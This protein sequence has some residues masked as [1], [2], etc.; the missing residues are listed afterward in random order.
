[1][2]TTK[3]LAVTR[4]SPELKIAKVKGLS[5]KKVSRVEAGHFS[6]SRLCFLSFQLLVQFVN[7]LSE[8]TQD[9]LDWFG[10]C[11]IDTSSLEQA[12]RIV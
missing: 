8:M 3:R 7:E 10:A 5:R 6:T 12:K 1:M 4:T 2:P 9:T 11:H